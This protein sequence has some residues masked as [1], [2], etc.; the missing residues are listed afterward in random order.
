VRSLLAPVSPTETEEMSE[1]DLPFNVLGRNEIQTI[2]QAILCVAKE[3][4]SRLPISHTLQREALLK[5]E[6]SRCG[7]SL[8]A[9]IGLNLVS[10]CPCLQTMAHGISWGRKRAPSENS[11][12]PEY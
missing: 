2:R 7:D 10:V 4:P 3:C 1:S 5:V 6:F 12:C 8:V 11:G 9:Q